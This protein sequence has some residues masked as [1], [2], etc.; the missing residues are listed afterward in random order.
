MTNRQHFFIALT[1]LLFVAVAGFVVGCDSDETPT[2]TGPN[3]AAGN[4]N[5]S[6]NVRFGERDLEG[7]ALGQR[8]ISVSNSSARA[9]D[10]DGDYIGMR[11]IV[12]LTNNHNTITFVTRFS[13]RDG[14]PGQDGRTFLS[15]NQYSLDPGETETVAKEDLGYRFSWEYETIIEAPRGHTLIEDYI[16]CPM[17]ENFYGYGVQF[18]SAPE[19]FGDGVAC[20]KREPNL[21]EGTLSCRRRGL[22]FDGDYHNG[23]VNCC[24]PS[25][26]GANT[27]DGMATKTDNRSDSGGGS[28][29]GGAASR[30]TPA[31]KA[32]E[33]WNGPSDSHWRFNCAAACLGGQNK[34][35]NCD[36]LRRI[37][38]DV[39]SACG[40]C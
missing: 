10:A 24:S 36:T 27:C 1:V 19:Q 23:R 31:E 12:R 28:D 35:S 22:D 37:G 33:G 17:P 32:L 20:I 14:R 4:G 18:R 8:S 13:Y 5:G 34:T 25:S 3:G 26:G 15:N 21:P 7:E 11:P 30:C 16:A 38:S 29:A 2:V 39:V 6:N 9:Y 40:W